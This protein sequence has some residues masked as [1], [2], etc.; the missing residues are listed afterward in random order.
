MSLINCKVSL[1]LTWSQNFVLTDLTT[2]TA[3]PVQE[4]HRKRP[5]VN[6]P[7][8][9]KFKISDAKLYVPVVA[10]LTQVNNNLLHQLKI[11]FKRNIKWNKYLKIAIINK[12]FNINYKC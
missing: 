10:L 6:A 4:G 1:I 3:V 11:G 8:G 5:A 9:A 2:Q 7:A 12:S